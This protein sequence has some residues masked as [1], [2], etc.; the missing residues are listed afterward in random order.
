LGFVKRLIL[1]DQEIA[2]EKASSVFGGEGACR[3]DV[4]VAFV[5]DAVP[6]Q[7]VHAKISKKKRSFAKA[8]LLDVKGRKPLAVEPQCRRF[9][10]CGRG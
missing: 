7:T 5:D 3:L 10:G 9:E 1:K 2:V 4:F 6:G 8:K